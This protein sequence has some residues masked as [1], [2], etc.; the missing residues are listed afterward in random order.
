ML[1]PRVTRMNKAEYKYL[2]SC[3]H[4][5]HIADL[6]KID[7]NNFNINQFNVSQIRDNTIIRDRGN[8]WNTNEALM[9]KKDKSSTKLWLKGMK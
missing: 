1:M 6:F 3:T 4:Y 7:P 2:L 9:I 5:S 8:N